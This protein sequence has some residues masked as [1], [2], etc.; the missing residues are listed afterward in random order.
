MPPRRPQ[1]SIAACVELLGSHSPK[2]FANPILFAPP[3][4]PLPLSTRIARLAAGPFHRV[5]KDPSHF[6]TIVIVVGL[7]ARREIEN[8]SLSHCPTQ[9]HPCVL[10]GA[11]RF[12]VDSF[13]W[14][15]FRWRYFKR[16]TI[17]L[18]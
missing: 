18:D 12:R 7:V 6:G 3:D 1:L 4:C 11:V 14:N 16:L 9:P 2:P 13:E 5:Y 17:A 10:L 8:L 15:R